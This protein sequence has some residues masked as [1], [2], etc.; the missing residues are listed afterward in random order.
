MHSCQEI[1]NNNAAPYLLGIAEATDE[2]DLFAAM[3]ACFPSPNGEPMANYLGIDAA[4]YASY[5]RLVAAKATTDGLTIIAKTHLHAPID[6]FL[7]CEDFASAPQYSKA[8]IDPKFAPLI[9]MLEDLDR[10]YLAERPRQTRTLH[11]YMLGV[12]REAAGAG[13]ARRLLIAGENLAVAN[14]FV[15]VIA[16]TTGEASRKLMLN[17][18]YSEVLQKPYQTYVF[19]G[20]NP[21]STMTEAR[22]LVLMEKTLP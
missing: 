7:I 6:G 17:C 13:L 3:Q 22:C 14:H 20:T 18:G 10:S 1:T 2:K 4:C 21:F 16:E 15:D 5:S 9:G 19:Q 8:A 11:L 12:R